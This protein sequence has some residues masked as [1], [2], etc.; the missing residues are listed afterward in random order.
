MDCTNTFVLNAE[1]NAFFTAASGE[2]TNYTIGT[3]RFW[4]LET[5]TGHPV[6]NIQGFKN[7]NIW[8]FDVVG[9][10]HGFSPNN[11]IIN[12]WRIDLIIVGQQPIISG[13]IVPVSN[14][15]NLSNSSAALNNY[16][17]GRYKTKI[18][19]SSPIQ[20]VTQIDF[21]RIAADGF[22]NQSLTNLYL[23]WFFTFVFYYTYE[24]E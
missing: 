6:F 4:Q 14:G 16:Q 3:E 20:S 18:E 23:H 1:K 8:G 9:D 7:V 19:L 24:G 17:L 22:A 12:D 2:F 5:V 13:N 11:G 21:V 15:F 10:I